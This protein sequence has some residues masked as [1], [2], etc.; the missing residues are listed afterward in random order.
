[1]L[2]TTTARGIDRALH[3]LRLGGPYQRRLDRHALGPPVRTAS[4]AAAKRAS[5]QS[6]QRSRSVRRPGRTKA[7]ISTRVAPFSM[8]RRQR[9]QRA[10][11]VGAALIV[12]VL[13]RCWKPRPRILSLYASSSSTRSRVTSSLLSVAVDR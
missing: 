9:R 1:M 11:P 2:P 12:Y 5:T 7:R 8:R 3:A 4:T 6:A 10:R 13:G